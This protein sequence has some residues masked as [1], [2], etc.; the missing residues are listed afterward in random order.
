MKG[1]NKREL[2]AYRATG[3]TPE[4]LS[5]LDSLYLAKCEEVSELIESLEEMEQFDTLYLMKCDEAAKLKELLESTKKKIEK[6]EKRPLRIAEFIE[7]A[8]KNADEHGFRTVLT[9]PSDYVALIHSEVSEVLEEFRSGHDATQTYYSANGKPE[10]VPMELAD[11]VIRCFDMAYA[12][13]IDLEGAIIE[14][15]EYNKQRPYLHGKKF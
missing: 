6:F 15:Q 8:G 3:L 2:R 1:K 14:K 12:Y 9:K 10:G 4:M 13:G 7:S 11:V 5:K